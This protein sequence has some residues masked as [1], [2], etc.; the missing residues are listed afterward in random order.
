MNRWPVTSIEHYPGVFGQRMQYEK[1]EVIMLQSDI[2][3]PGMIPKVQH[4]KGATKAHSE[5]HSKD[6]EFVLLSS[7]LKPLSLD[8]AVIDHS[9]HRVEP[10]LD[11]RAQTVVSSD[12]TIF[13]WRAV[14]GG[15]DCG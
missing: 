5:G 4:S 6:E 9:F 3:R 10:Y 14:C 12:G 2:I 8:T 7:V 15:F 11:G 13:A 1:R